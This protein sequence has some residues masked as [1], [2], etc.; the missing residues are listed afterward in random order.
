MT[1]AR[2]TARFAL[3]VAPVALMA[4]TSFAQ[5]NLQ[6]ESRLWIDGTSTVRSFTCTAKDV[7]AT[8]PAEA[9]AVGALLAGE[10]A[11]QSAEVRIAAGRIDCGNGTMNDHMYKALKVE[12]NPTIELKVASYDMNSAAGTITGKLNGTLT[13]GGVTKPVVIDAKARKD[14]VGLRVT[15]SYPVNMKEYGLKPPTLM[16]GTLKVNELVKVNFDLLLND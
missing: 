3:C 12:Q 13:I 14:G 1:T 8:I 7:Q 9:D 10:K 4:L 11:V 6:P 5:L 15:G 16:L 2:R